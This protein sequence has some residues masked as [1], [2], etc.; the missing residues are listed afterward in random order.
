M[1]VHDNCGDAPL[2]SVLILS[3]RN[4]DGILPTLDSVLSQDYPNIEIVI[5][6]D[7][8]PGFE[9]FAPALA[10]RV[11]DYP[12]FKRSLVLNPIKEN[13]GTVKNANAAIGLAHGRYIKTI[14]PDDTFSV[15]CAISDY[16]GF[17][18]GNDYLVC[19]AKMRGIDESGRIYNDLAACETDYK[20]LGSLSPAEILNRLYSR[21]FLPGA[22][23]FFD[24]RVFDEYGLFDENVRLIEDYTYWLH[25]AQN[26]VRFGFLDEVLIDYSLSGVSSSGS[27]GALFM[28]DMI[29]I[30]E[31]YIF[32]FDERYGVLQ[33]V[34][35]FLKKTGLNYYCE[36]ALVSEK[37]QFE[38]VLFAVKYFPFCVYTRI[39]N[40]NK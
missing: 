29:S 23:E 25:L 7:G 31:R 13:A 35:N 2:V 4:L 38:R 18:E 12:E 36:K 30:Y 5:S 1:R 10:S 17:M 33:P 16:V 15:D 19:F 21:N 24:K 28:D 26:D 34:Y 40:K 9:D 27:Y 11:G 3:Y 6:D 32:P 8:T 39:A 37:T 22:A 14:S 20:M